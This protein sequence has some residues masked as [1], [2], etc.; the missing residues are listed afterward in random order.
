MTNVD[1]KD[2]DVLLKVSE[3][4]KL[5][6]FKVSVDDKVLYEYDLTELVIS[7]KE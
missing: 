5:K 3:E 7:P 1:T 2:Y 6:P 4:S